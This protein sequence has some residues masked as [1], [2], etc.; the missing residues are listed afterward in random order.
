MMRVPVDKMIHNSFNWNDTIGGFISGD[1]VSLIAPHSEEAK[2]AVMMERGHVVE[3]EF[4]PNFPIDLTPDL[5]TYIKSKFVLDIIKGKSMLKKNNSSLV[6]FNGASETTY[7]VTYIYDFIKH[8]RR[9]NDTLTIRTNSMSLIDMEKGGPIQIISPC[10][11]WRLW[12]APRLHCEDA[13][14]VRLATTNEAPK[15]DQE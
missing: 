15:E 5:T 8:Y 13:P 6:M 1:H 9:K 11:H 4:N 10:K 7:D 12:V 14:V 3:R 2:M